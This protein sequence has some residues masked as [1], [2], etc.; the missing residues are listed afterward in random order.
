MLHDKK[1]R[2]QRNI[3]GIYNIYVCVYISPMFSNSFAHNYEHHSIILNIFF[4]YFFLF[5]FLY[6]FCFSFVPLNFIFVSYSVSG[7]RSCCLVQYSLEPEILLLQSPKCQ[8]YKYVPYHT[9]LQLF[10]Y[11]FFALRYL[12]VCLFC[13][14]NF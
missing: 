1:I 11:L 14:F 10:M 5:Q 4:F 2:E 9:R 12:V 6:I 13:C 7:T 3:Y 8:D